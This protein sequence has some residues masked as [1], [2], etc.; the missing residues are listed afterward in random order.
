MSLY[1]HPIQFLNHLFSQINPFIDSNNL[2]N[3]INH[4]IN[5]IN[6]LINFINQ[7]IILTLLYA[8]V[9]IN[10]YTVREI[11]CKKKKKM[12]FMLCA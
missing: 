2:L 1:M 10:V 7:N 4:L 5:L 8:G 3:L 9:S 12:P 11:H 6:N